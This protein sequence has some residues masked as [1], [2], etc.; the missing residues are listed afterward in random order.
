MGITMKVMESLEKLNKATMSKIYNSIIRNRIFYSFNKGNF[1][2]ILN[3]CYRYDFRS[4]LWREALY[5]S[6][7]QYGKDKQT[8][9][10]K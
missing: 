6:V 8:E 2:F 10:S 1:A 3:N 9:T 4:F 7:L 5:V